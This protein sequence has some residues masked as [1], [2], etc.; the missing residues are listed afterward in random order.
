MRHLVSMMILGMGGYIIYN[1]PA[2]G[3]PVAFVCSLLAFFLSLRIHKHQII[4][5]YLKEVY[6]EDKEKIDQ[7]NSKKEDNSAKSA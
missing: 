4:D 6:K 1:D 3:A 2:S 7:L 5:D